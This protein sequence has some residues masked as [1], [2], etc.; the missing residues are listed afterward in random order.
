MD[1]PSGNLTWLKNLSFIKGSW[2]A[3]LPCYGQ[4]EFWDLKW[5]RVVRDWDLTLI[6]GGVRLYT[7]S[8]YIRKELTL[9]KGGV[10]L[11]ITIHQKRIDFDEGWCET[12]QNIT[13]HH[14]RV[15][16][17]EGWCETLH[18]ITIHQKR[19][20]FDEGWCETLHNNTSEKNWLWWRV[21]WNFTL[22][23]D[24]SQK[25]WPA[26][27]LHGLCFGEEAGAR[28]RAF[29]RVKWLQPAMKGPRV[30]GGCGC[31]RFMRESVPP[32]CSATTRRGWKNL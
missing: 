19:I 16:L 26:W 3:I 7:T 31:G 24:T 22:H 21:V 15:D 20:D 17:D 8:Q 2:E 12:L 28:N 4:I 18:Y 23:N 10:R 13:I 9:M 25:N 6:K 11:C 27:M 32:L 14:K 1:V 29:F 5:W 30:C